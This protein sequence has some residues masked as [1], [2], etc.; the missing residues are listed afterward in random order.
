[1]DLPQLILDRWAPS[2]GPAGCS[3]QAVARSILSAVPSIRA[4]VPSIR[5]AAAQ[6]GL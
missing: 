1:V 3:I 6:P 2:I 5:A 4:A